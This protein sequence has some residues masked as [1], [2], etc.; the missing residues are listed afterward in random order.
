MPVVGRWKS[1]DGD[2]FYLAIGMVVRKGNPVREK[3]SNDK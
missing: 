1:K 2:V 3:R